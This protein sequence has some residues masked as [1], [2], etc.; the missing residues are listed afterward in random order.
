MFDLQKLKKD[1]FSEAL[2]C[3]LPVYDLRCEEIAKLVPIGNWALN[4]ENLLYLFASWRKTFNRFFLTQ[5]ETSPQST[6]I[7]LKNQS[8][9]QTNRIFFAIYVGNILIGHMGLSNIV[10]EEALT[11]NFIRGKSGGHSDLMYFA[12][13]TLLTFAFEELELKK[14]NGIVLS[15]NFMAMALHERFGFQFEERY[16]LKK[17]T[18][19]NSTTLVKCDKTQATEKFYLDKIKLNKSSFLKYLKK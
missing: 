5:F 16:Y 9:A 18:S 14:I 2:K 19:K 17:I 10:K 12:E 6:A 11:D 13:K 4:D 8:I 15:N 3:S 7:Y 1:S